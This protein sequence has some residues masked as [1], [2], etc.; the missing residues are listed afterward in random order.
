MRKI[1]I[2][3]L[4]VVLSTSTAFATCFTSCT[5]D[6][7]YNVQIIQYEDRWEM[8]IRDETYNVVHR[9]GL[10]GQYS[11]TVCHGTTPCQI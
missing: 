7:G 1:M 9:S 3:I 4:F 2:M 8:T 6:E 10:P 5:S 11:G